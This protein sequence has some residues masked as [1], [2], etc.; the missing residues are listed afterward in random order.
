MNENDLLNVS[1]HHLNVFGYILLILISVHTQTH[2]SI[3]FAYFWFL[4]LSS[5]YLKHAEINFIQLRLIINDIGLF[6]HQ[7]IFG[8]CLLVAYS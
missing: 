3:P 7:S 1:N 6:R 5:F 8:L 2:F 4:V